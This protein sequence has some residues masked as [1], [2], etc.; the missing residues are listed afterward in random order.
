MQLHPLLRHFGRCAARTASQSQGRG[1][2]SQFQYLVVQYQ[3]SRCRLS[4]STITALSPPITSLNPNPSCHYRL[5]VSRESH[6]VVAV[7]V[8]GSASRAPYPLFPSLLRHVAGGYGLPPPPPPYP[9][10]SY[11]GMTSSMAAVAGRACC[12]SGAGV[13]RARCMYLV[14]LLAAMP[15]RPAINH[16]PH[17]V[18]LLALSPLAQ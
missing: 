7:A 1:G 9:L 5:V 11:F 2:L 13:V 12:L 4:G 10:P 14:L 16:Q 8:V 17:R 18:H 15:A 6:Y 3:P